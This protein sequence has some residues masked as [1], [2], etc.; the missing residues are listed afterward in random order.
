MM[1]A[2]IQATIGPAIFAANGPAGP[3][4]LHPR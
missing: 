3:P 2:M 4:A 1:S